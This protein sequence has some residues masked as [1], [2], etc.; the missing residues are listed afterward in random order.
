MTPCNIFFNI[1]VSLRRAH[2][3]SWLSSQLTKIFVLDV[4]AVFTIWTPSFGFN[5]CC[6]HKITFL[7][8]AVSLWRCLLRWAAMNQEEIVWPYITCNTKQMVFQNLQGKVERSCAL[9]KAKEQRFLVVP[10]QW[11]W[12]T[13]VRGFLP[14][15]CFWTIKSIYQIIKAETILTAICIALKMK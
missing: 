15:D 2:L 6:R 14:S 4:N 1:H 5:N 11:L 10:Q 12:K 3:C 8:P 9:H 7:G 13:T